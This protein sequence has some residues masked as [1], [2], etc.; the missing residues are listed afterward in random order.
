MKCQSKELSR[1][2]VCR[3]PRGS[4]LNKVPGEFCEGFFGGF[5]GPVFLEK[6]GG[7]NPPKNPRQFSNQNLGVSGPKSTLQGFGLEEL[8]QVKERNIPKALS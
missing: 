3:N 8:L 4:F 6:T 5:F 7:K 1:K 2:G